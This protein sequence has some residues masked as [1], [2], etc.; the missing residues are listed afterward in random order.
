[1]ARYVMANRRAGKFHETGKRASRGA[2]SSAMDLLAAS[3]SVLQDLEPKDDT[4]RR[5][6]HFDADPTKVSAMAATLSPDVILE[7]EIRRWPVSD[8]PR[9]FATLALDAPAVPAAVGAGRQRVVTVT[10]GAQ[11]GAPIPLVGAD[12]TLFLRGPGGLPRKLTT[13]TN[14]QG[15]ASFTFSAQFLA[16]ALV[17]VPA[18]DFWS[19]VVRGVT[20]NPTVECPP[21]PRT[22]PIGWWHGAMGVASF[23]ATRG[24]GVRV[25]VVDTDAGPHPCLFHV[26]DAGAFIGGEIFPGAGA[27]VDSH[28]SHVCGIIG[29]RPT[30]P[31][32]FAGMAPGA[33]LVIA[34]VFPGK[35][36]RANQGDIVSAIDELSKAQHVDLIN[37]SLGSGPVEPASEIERDA[38]RDALERGTLCICAAGNS[39]GSVEYP[40]AYPECVAVSALGLEGWGPSGSVAA[41]RLPTASDRFGSDH[42]YLANFS[43]SGAQIASAAPGVGILSTVPARHGL[44]DPYAAMD[45]TSMASPAACGALAAILAA[46]PI[47]L[48]L[49]RDTIRAE[50]ARQILRSRCR[51][52]GLVPAYEGR[53]VP[54]VQ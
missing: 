47:Y 26:V 14:H 9:D 48:A 44:A 51:D 7:P 22:G 16:A 21:L 10:G 4:L 28:G 38:I 15:V 8:A 50:H 11:V 17:V 18:G 41:S 24:T 3:V 53:G 13:Q 19:M 30:S 12:L 42:L 1:M 39:G 34:R 2:I 37:L 31:G 52:I 36:S 35:D 25:G 43:C 23:D 46:D 27:D 49:P 5:I 32:Q 40:A 20:A 54:V 6:V 29:A 33:D 45:G